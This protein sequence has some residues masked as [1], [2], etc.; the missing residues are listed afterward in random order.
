MILISV[1]MLAG[2]VALLRAGGTLGTVS[3]LDSGEA[4]RGTQLLQQEIP[5]TGS[6]SFDL[7]FGSDTM[8]TSDTA[9]QTAMEQALSPLAADTRVRSVVTYYDVPAATRASYLSLDGHHALAHVRVRDDTTHARRYYPELRGLV[10]SDRLQVMATNGLAVVDDSNA[11]LERDLRRGE[12]VSLPLALVLLV[13]VFGSIVSGLLPLGIGALTIAGGIAAT[14]WLNRVTDVSLY[15]SNLV[16]LIGLGLAIDY[17]LFI[18]SRF[19]EELAAGR[20]VERAVSVTLA[21]AGRAM[22]F[23]GLTVAVGLSGMLFFRGTFLASIGVAGGIVVA[24]AVVYGLTLLP[25][26]LSVAGARVDLGRVRP[27][28]RRRQGPGLWARHADAVMRHP[29]ACSIPVVVTLLLLG[30][31][32]LH[33]HLAGGRIALLP[34]SAPSRRAFDLLQAQFPDQSLTRIPVVV[35]FPDGAPLA[36]DHVASL[37]RLSHTI[38]QV[39]GVA[40]V[41][42][43]VDTS[44]SLDE[45]GYEALYARPPS[46]LPPDVRSVAARTTGSDIA[47]FA[48][49]TH[50]AE[51]S[52][53]ARRLVSAIRGLH[54]QT[55][56]MYVTGTTATDLDV[57]A[58]ITQH[59]SAAVAFVT[60]TTYV[61]LFMLLG[62]IVLP[63][64]AVVTNL[65]SIS[66]S[67][68]ALVWIFQDGHLSGVL[69]FTPQPI[70]PNVPILLFCIVFGLSMDYE[71]F[72]LT[73]IKEEYDKAGDVAGAIVAGLTRSGRLITGAAAIMISIFGAFALADVVLIKALGLTMGIA[74][75]IDSTLVR[76]LLVPAVMRLL[77]GWNWWIPSPLRS[78]YLRLGLGEVSYTS[79]ARP[80]GD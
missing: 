60:I 44:P 12:L 8:L 57:V 1:G 31:P 71:V 50:E 58:F 24:L 52:D 21:T 29:L 80:V 13:L 41:E 66:A 51:E 48:V 23:S 26:L 56:Q 73:R 17:S 30:T 43:I 27:A 22:A 9:F 33:A 53:G 37:Y 4:Y 19:R 3:P 20:E 18:V 77:G 69:G 49:V 28:A 5:E 40:R 47:L 61:V 72:L 16:T 10:R 65:L 75:A 2:S 74:V 70:D 35:Y 63:L 55:G 78:L 42:S 59:A 6:A 39:P 62:S 25:A 7:I 79:R 68:G 11:T 64:K 38:G 45:A 46:Q 54:P 15:A 14:L 67:F 32:V 36:A 76:A 34:P